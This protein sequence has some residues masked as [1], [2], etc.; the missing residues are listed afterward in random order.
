[1]YYSYLISIKDGT[2]VAI[3]LAKRKTDAASG[4][5]LSLNVKSNDIPTFSDRAAEIYRYFDTQP[6]LNIKLQQEKH[7]ISIKADDWFI[8]TSLNND[9]YVLM[10]NVLY[11]LP[12]YDS[13]IKTKGI[14]RCVLKVPTGAVSINPGRESLNYDEP[15]IAY[16]NKRF[17]TVGKEYL[18]TIKD[19]IDAQTS[20][21]DKVLI[22]NSAVKE[23]PYALRDQILITWLPLCVSKLLQS[24]AYAPSVANSPSAIVL[25]FTETHS[26]RLYTIG[27]KTTDIPHF[28][29]SKFVLIDKATN[30]SSTITKLK[31]TYPNIVTVSRLAGFTVDEFLP[32]A[33]HWLDELGIDYIKLS[34]YYIAQ[35]KVKQGTTPRDAGIYVSTPKGDATFATSTLADNKDYWYVELSGYTPTSPDYTKLYSFIQDLRCFKLDIPPLVGVSKKYLSSVQALDSFKPAKE[36]LQ[37]LLDTITITVIDVEKFNY[38]LKFDIPL[39]VEVP[40]KIATYYNDRLRKAELEQT[41][42]W[43]TLSHYNYYKDTFNINHTLHTTPLTYDQLVKDY[44]LIPIIPAYKSDALLHYFSL[45]YKNEQHSLHKTE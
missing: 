39:P 17:I 5:C 11:R 40:A 28:F 32:I 2:P 36:E 43:I 9:N 24:S 25:K 22:Y 30:Y 14:T 29:K 37:K 1:M 38:Y 35:P 41:T 19:T 45:E 13:Q 15:T 10:S 21:I 27:K 44:P 42:T 4:L 31:E 16:L 34:D 12:R 8:D 7:N 3:C 20:N 23:A 18:Q 33:K 6:T 26:S